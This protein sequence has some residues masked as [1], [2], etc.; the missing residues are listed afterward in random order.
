MCAL[1]LEGHHN[2]KDDFSN[3]FPPSPV[4]RAKVVLAN[5]I[6]A[7]SLKGNHPIKSTIE[8]LLKLNIVVECDIL[9]EK[10]K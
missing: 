8:Y 5:F 2:T 6:P 1:T 10:M 4:F 3:P 9:S 7:H